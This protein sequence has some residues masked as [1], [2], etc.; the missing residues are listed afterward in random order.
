MEELYGDMADDISVSTMRR[1]LWPRVMQDSVILLPKY[2]RYT[3][4]I[5]TKMKSIVLM[6]CR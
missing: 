4:A 2:D 5:A 6:G 3:K 1:I